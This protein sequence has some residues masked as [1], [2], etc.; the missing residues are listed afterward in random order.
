MTSLRYPSGTSRR[1]SFLAVLIGSALLLTGVF[2]SGA[3]AR[4]AEFQALTSSPAPLTAVTTDPGTSLI[5]AQ[6][7]EGTK[8]FVYDPRTNAWTELAEAPID[9]GNNGGAAYLNGKIYV[10]YTGEKE[11]LSVYDIATN[12]WTTIKNPIEK[13]TGDITAGNGKLYIAAFE[14]FVSFDPATGVTTPLAAPPQWLPAECEEGFEK[15]G[16]LVFDGSKIYGHQGNGCSGFGV[17]DIAGNSWTELPFVP[18][19]EEEGNEPESAVAGSAINP[20]TNA[21][22]TTGPYD[23]KTLFRYDIDGGAWSTS[24]LPFAVED[25][26]MAYVSLTGYEG[27]YIVEG[28]EG[29]QFTRYTEKN[30]T[31]LSPSMSAAVVGSTKGGEITYSVQVK[32]NGPEH[33][34]GVTLSD[35]LPA[36]STLV[37]ATSTQ[38]SCTGTST[39]ACN[40]GG[41][42]SGTSAGMTIKVKVGFGT[43]T[44]TATVSSLAID[45]NKANDSA[46]VTSALPRPCV[47]PKLKKLKVKKAKK[48]LRAAGCKPGKV[49][50]RF[51]KKIKK[52]RVIRSGKHRGTKLPPGAKVKL[53][54]SRGP[55]PQHPQGHSNP[56]GHQ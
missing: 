24:T 13:A 2:A 17:Y 47:V 36:G 38:G 44:N 26:G 1:S 35:P 27:T 14:K 48:A 23:G 7:N 11:E 37:S 8:F 21:Y 45:N 42:A 6:E 28:E 32:N 31:D 52:G 34:G 29:P 50:R 41:L 46:S 49:Q 30:E 43:F 25:N 51:S 4:V 20:V 22:L 15:W 54:V 12:S 5:Y 19:I 10:V 3:Q 9:S 55:K 16:G 40:L 39:V 56:K 53:T 33:A 18:L